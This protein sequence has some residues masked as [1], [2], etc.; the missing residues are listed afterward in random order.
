MY[1]W[2]DSLSSALVLK[3]ADG[4]VQTGGDAT[5]DD[6]VES[7]LSYEEIEALFEDI[8]LDIQDFSS[9]GFGEE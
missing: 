7:T 3:S 4:T 1:Y 5:G 2:V 9:L 6:G 8:G